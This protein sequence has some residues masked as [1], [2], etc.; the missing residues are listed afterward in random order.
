MAGP[1][2]EEGR[3]RRWVALAGGEPGLDNF[4]QVLAALRKAG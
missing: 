2:E 3:L 4:R 1:V